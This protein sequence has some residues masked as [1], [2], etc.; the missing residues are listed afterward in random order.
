MNIKDIKNGSIF[1]FNSSKR[2]AIKVGDDH[3]L[4]LNHALGPAER[5][6]VISELYDVDEEVEFV[7]GS[8]HIAC[9]IQ[10]RLDK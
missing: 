1:I 6:G 5:L 2:L 4:M 10:K 7:I 9:A 8:R 3:Y